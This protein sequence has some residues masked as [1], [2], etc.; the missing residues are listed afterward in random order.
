MLLQDGDQF[1][2][3]VLRR[4]SAGGHRHGRHALQPG[5]IDL[6]GVVHQV[7]RHAGVLRTPPP[8]ASNWSCS[9]NPPPAA[10]RKPEPPPSPPAGGSRWRSRC[11]AP[12]GPGSPETAASAAPRCPRSHP[13]SASSASG[14]TTRVG[15]ADSQP[16]PHPPPSRPGPCNSGASPSVPDHLVVIPVADQHDG[17]ALLARTAPLPGAPWS[18]AGRWRR[19]P[20]ASARPPAARTAGDTPCALKITRAPSGTSS[21]SSTK[22]APARR[23]S[24]TTCRLWTISLRT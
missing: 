3:Q 20:A 17:V 15:S 7:R 23:S 10:G 1:L 8:A 14:S 19:S 18:P 6:A 13:G 21:S 9:A 12:A 16:C 11:P 2:H 5:R 4:R 22:I 24:S